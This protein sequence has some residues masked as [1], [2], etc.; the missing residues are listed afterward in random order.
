[1][2]NAFKTD[3]FRRMVDAE[4]SYA[5]AIYAAV[6]SLERRAKLINELIDKELGRE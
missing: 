6:K 5:D 1:M 2:I 4:L 3:E